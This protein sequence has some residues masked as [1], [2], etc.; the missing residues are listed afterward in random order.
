MLNM[1]WDNYEL[2]LHLLNPCNFS[3]ALLACKSAA[4]P[5]LPTAN[6]TGSRSHLDLEGSQPHRGQQQ[7]PV[8][9]EYLHRNGGMSCPHDTG[10]QLGQI[11]RNLAINQMLSSKY[12]VLKF[13]VIC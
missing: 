5:A 4:S 11:C 13:H 12:Y 2:D 7:S 3:K 6:D 9:S 8:P 1:A 10:T